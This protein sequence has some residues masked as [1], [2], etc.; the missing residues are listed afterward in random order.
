[1]KNIYLAFALLTSA[2]ATAQN[3]LKITGGATIKTT[4]GA[5]ITV[6]DL[7]LDNDGAI[8]LVAGD[9]TFRFSGSTNANLSGTVSPV[10]DRLE[11]AKSNAQIMLMTDISIASGIDFTSGLLDL[12]NHIITLQ[13][14]ALLNGES[15]TS[16]ITGNAGGYIEIT[17]T[18]NAPSS[19]N[20]GNLGAIITSSQNLG[21]T[22]IRRGHMPQTG[23]LGD[24]S[25]IRRYFDIIPSNNI[26]LNATLR[27][28]YFD[29]ELNGYDES[30]MIFWKSDDLIN[31]TK[32]GHSSRDVINNY[33]EKTG[34]SD[35]SRWTLSQSFR[36]RIANTDHPKPLSS[37][38]VKIKEQWAAW[39][40][41]VSKTVYLIITTD[42][43]TKSTTSIFDSKG[44]LIKKRQDNLTAGK[45]T[46]EIDVNGLAAGNYY[47]VTEWNAGQAKASAV[48][49]KL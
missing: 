5:V 4:G 30:S 15:E 12:N 48:F 13:P 11:L 26:S 19:L 6:E 23:D 3:T 35:F 28:G 40:N 2:A 46:L 14:A 16:R 25:S 41:P 29:A 47:L 43:A 45:N 20:P 9:G 37:T 44:T 10:F 24:G 21:S 7:H 27:S 39:P 22:I 42:K 33:V 31:W 34:I 32:I 49:V 36:S 38:G 1:M 18:L 8:N 17:N